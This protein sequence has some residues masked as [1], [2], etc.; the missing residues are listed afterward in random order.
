MESPMK[1]LYLSDLDGTLLPS[2]GSLSTYATKIANGFV[3]AG[4]VFPIQLPGRL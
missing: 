4:A 3:R 1:I 2:D